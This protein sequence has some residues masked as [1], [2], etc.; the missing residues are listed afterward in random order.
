VTRYLHG[1]LD[2]VISEWLPEIEEWSRAQMV[3]HA[4][5]MIEGSSIRV[6]VIEITFDTRQMSVRQVAGW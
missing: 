6:E 5:V 4:A 2:A 3:E 1:Q